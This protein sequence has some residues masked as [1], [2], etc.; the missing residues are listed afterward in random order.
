MS[1][2]FLVSVTALAALAIATVTA[3]TP[4]QAPAAKPAAPATKAK[5]SAIPRTADGHPD[6]QGVW[7]NATI[8]PMTRPTQFKDKP[9]ISDA[10]AKAYESKDHEELYK[11]DGQSDGPLIAAAGSSGT[12]GYNVL[13]VDRGTELARVDGQARTSLIING[14]CL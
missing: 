9:T 14:I 6:L 8:T 4:A 7:T 3:Q 10:E 11:Q 1:T 12:G 2:R 5:S 13:F